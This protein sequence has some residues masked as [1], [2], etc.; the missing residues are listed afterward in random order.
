MGSSDDKKIDYGTVLTVG[1]IAFVCS[2]II[3]IFAPAF[4][5]FKSVY[6]VG[7]FVSLPIISLIIVLIGGIGTDIEAKKEKGKLQKNICDFQREYEE[8]RERL[9]MT[10]CDTQVTLLELDD[11]GFH[12]SIQQYLWIEDN[13]LCMFPMSKYYI[14]RCTSSTVKPS[15]SD[16]QLISIPVNNIEYFEEIGE[17]RKYTTVSGGG[18]SIKGAVL[19]KIIADDVGAIIASRVPIKSEI[20]SEDERRIELIYK[21]E[22]NEILNLEFEHDAYDALK[23]LIPAKELRRIMGL[24]ASNRAGESC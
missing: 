15:I 24:N 9:G 23:Y 12:S 14:E 2:S 19:G 6:V 13:N 18:S 21:N 7:F 5:S 3:C 17:L 11:S 10:A 20:V 22:K 8:Y 4:I 16:L 1:V